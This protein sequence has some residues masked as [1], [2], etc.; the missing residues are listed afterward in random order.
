MSIIN[1]FIDALQIEIDEC[2]KGKGG[3]KVSITNG[4]LIRQDSDSFIYEFSM[5]SILQVLDGTPASIEIRGKEYECEVI[6]TNGNKIQLNL[7]QLVAQQVPSAKLKINTWFLYERLKKKYED[8]LNCI[9]RFNNSMRFFE[10]LDSKICDTEVIPSYV[11]REDSLNPSQKEAVKSSL[12]DFKSIIWGPP[13][14]GKTLAIS[15]AIANHINLGRKVLLVSHSNNAVDQALIKTA[16]Y[17]YQ[18]QPTNEYSEFK[19]VRFG[20]PQKD[21]YDEIK[22]DFKLLLIEDIVREKSLVLV[23]EKDELTQKCN[24]IKEIR[25]QFSSYDSYIQENV[26]LTTNYNN[27]KTQFESQKEELIELREKHHLQTLKLS[28][29][30]TAGILQRTFLGLN[31]QKIQVNLQN[32]Q[33][34]INETE[35][36]IN[37]SNVQLNMLSKDI[38]TNQKNLETSKSIVS[39]RLL[40]LGKRTIDIGHEIS[41][42]TKEYENYQL[43]LNIINQTINDLKAKIL[44]EAMLIAT[45]LTKSYLSKELENLDFDILIVDEVSMAPMPMLFWA[46]SKAKKGVTIIGDFKQLPP[47]C[48]SKDELAIKWL[49]KSIFD[50]LKIHNYSSAQ[51]NGVKLLG[52]QFRMN[53]SICDLVRSNIYENKLHDSTHVKDNVILDGISGT[54]AICLIDTSPA[55]SMVL[56]IR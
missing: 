25:E 44:S 53:K 54:S 21:K 4:I 32:I 30:Q 29:A 37:K 34:K 31:E 13:G 14:T 45:T 26:R 12:N 49:G 41:I 46:I 28:K 17:I 27:E 10:G 20:I 35:V 9:S 5:D 7:Q 23:K 22:K 40:E 48:I 38:I 42:L 8:N 3:N 2:K 47:I 56:S 24:Q 43:R 18:K 50:L 16:D 11:D 52:E 6:S 55:Q 15:R 19:L 36:L 51:T 39:A 33:R 1:E